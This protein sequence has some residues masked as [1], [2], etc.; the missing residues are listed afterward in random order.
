[1]STRRRIVVVWAGACLA[2][3]AATSTLNSGSYTDDSNTPA[4][5]ATPTGTY[6][7]QEI[8][9]SIEQARAEARREQQ[10]MIDA[11]PDV[12][13]Q[14]VIVGDVAVPEECLGEAKSP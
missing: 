7:C 14:S 2:G 5:E 11:S 12:A 8:Y 9:D 3:L 1:M 6:D 4:Q 10:D 13:Y